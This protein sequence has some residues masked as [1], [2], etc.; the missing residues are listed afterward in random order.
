MVRHGDPDT[1]HDAAESVNVTKDRAEARLIAS[2]MGPDFTRNEFY[3]ECRRRGMPHNRAD[4]LRRRLSDLISPM[5]LLEVVGGVR[6][7]GQQVLRF[8]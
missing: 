5:E 7:Q 8:R 1:S 3:L 4:S 2:E 6:R